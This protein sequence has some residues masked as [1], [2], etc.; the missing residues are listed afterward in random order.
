[1]AQTRTWWGSKSK[2]RSVC[3]GLSWLLQMKLAVTFCIVLV[4][5]C[6]IDTSL[7]QGDGGRGGGG[8]RRLRDERSALDQHDEVHVGAA[9]GGGGGLQDWRSA[10]RVDLG[11]SAQAQHDKAHSKVM[12]DHPR[13]WVLKRRCNM[14][15]NIGHC[16]LLEFA[17]DTALP[18][19]ETDCFIALWRLMTKLRHRN[20]TVLYKKAQLTQWFYAQQ[21][22]VYEG[23]YGRNLSSV[24]NPTLEPN[25]TSIGKPVAKL[26]P[27]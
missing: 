26:W 22:C 19:T 20:C 1:M 6:L 16:W 27:F 4:L 23:P 14:K 9:G 5:C 3:D 2:D 25:I 17:N 11:R 13:R 21:Q 7:A 15:Q 24:R 10:S 8:S 18:L 12:S